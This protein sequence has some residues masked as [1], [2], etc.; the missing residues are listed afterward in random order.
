MIGAEGG[1]AQ[2]SQ[3]GSLPIVNDNTTDT[4]WDKWGASANNAPDTES[5]CTDNAESSFACGGWRDVF[6]LDRQNQ[7]IAVYNLT[8]NNLSPTHGDCS[9]PQ[10][11]NESQCTGAGLT[12]TS[13]FDE[14]KQLFIDAATQ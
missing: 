1:T 3:S 7:P 10:Y 6:I 4:V 12:W 8:L 11:S 13:N 9:D 14:L 2:A 5:Y